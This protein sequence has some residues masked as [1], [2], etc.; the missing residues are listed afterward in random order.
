MALN[1]A[2]KTLFTWQGQSYNVRQ[3]PAPVFDGWVRQYVEEI[4]DVD[5]GEWDIYDR[6]NIVNALL[7]GKFLFLVAGESGSS[8]LRS[9]REMNEAEAKSSA[10]PVVAEVP[11]EK[12]ELQ[13]SA[14]K[15][16][17]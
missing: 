9:K 13:G 5:T 1:Q 3:A 10:V 15:E 16:A 2:V 14:M 11:Q 8:V 4:Q 7:Q 17:S 12:T 6:W